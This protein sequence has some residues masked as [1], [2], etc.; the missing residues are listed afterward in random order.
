MNDERGRLGVRRSSFTVHR[1]ALLL[2]AIA[3]ATLAIS[4]VRLDSATADEGAHIAAGLVKLR[5]GWLSYF[6]EQ[7][8]LMNVLSALPL[9]DFRMPDVWQRDLGRGGHWR[10]GHALLYRS[11][12]DAYALLFRARL[13]TIALFLALCFAVY[14]VVK[15]EVGRRW[16][17]VAFA[18]TGFCPNLLAHGR[19]ATVDL[20]VTAF[21]FI[22]FAFLQKAVEDRHSCLS[23]ASALPAPENKGD[24]QECLSSTTRRGGILWGAFCGLFA[25]CALLSKTSGAILVPFFAL[26]VALHVWRTRDWK[27][28]IA[29]I[30]AA[31]VAGIGTLYAVTFAL[32]SDN[33]LAAKFAETP[34]ILVPWLQYKQHVDAIRFWYGTGHENPQFL[35]GQFSRDGW[36][37]YYFVAFLLK[38]TLA[39]ILLF[40]LTLVAARRRRSLAMHGSLMFIALFFAVSM[41]SH[42][43]LGI[44]YILPIYPFLY[45]AIAVALSSVVIDRRR[46]IAVGVLVAWHCVSSL[47]AYPSYLSYFN[48]LIGSHRNADRFLID[49]NLDWGQ[50][51]RRLRVWA[52]ANGVD[53][54]LVDYFGGGDPAYE[55]GSGAERWS[56]PQRQLLPK[57]WFALSRHFYR[58]SFDPTQSPI[59]YDEYLQASRARYVTTVGGSIDV[60]RVD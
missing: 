39:A 46:A 1:V 33:Y 11:G 56:A 6:P 8:P 18:L 45:T 24:R 59:T 2:L 15:R 52:D 41:T 5:H 50:D 12:N 40:I 25:A 36:P 13:P 32:A 37:H 55:L 28:L 26:V 34:R 49:S 54:I 43:A 57:G 48:E 51:L 20:A 9:G 10:A 29:P 3:V 35:L 14:F 30:L 16:A 53:R 44:R 22:A 42:I 47:I 23:P 38:T 27:P 58:V 31:I 19:L 7:P 17:L 21:G 60:Y 4:S